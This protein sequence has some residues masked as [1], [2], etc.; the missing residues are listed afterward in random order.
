MPLQRRK[1]PDCSGLKHKPGSACPK[2]KPEITSPKPNPASSVPKPNPANSGSKPKPLTALPRKPLPPPKPGLPAYSKITDFAARPASAFVSSQHHPTKKLSLD[3]LIASR[4]LSESAP[5]PTSPWMTETKPRSQTSISSDRKQPL[6]PPTRFHL[7]S[8]RTAQQPQTI[9]ELHESVKS[10]TDQTYGEE[11]E[12]EEE[13]EAVSSS[14]YHPAGPMLPTTS[15]TH[16][17]RP[18]PAPAG[19]SPSRSRYGSAKEPARGGV[20]HGTR[21]STSHTL[22]D[23]SAPVPPL[24]TLLSARRQAEARVS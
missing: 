7:P 2:P 22:L 12:E 11:E 19:S 6:L 1:S 17:V 9:P 21:S 3:S 18:E 23:T 10:A 16:S 24:M 8:G 5:K 13:E 20:C 4:Q 14:L 15:V